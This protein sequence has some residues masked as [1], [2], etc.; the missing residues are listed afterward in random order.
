MP[1]AASTE[2]LE[3]TVATLRAGDDVDAVYACSR[4]DRLVA[5]SGTPYLALELRDRTGAIP[6]RAFRNADVLAGRF[7]RGDLGQGRGT[8]ERF[9]DEVAGAGGG[10]AR[11]G[12]GEGDPPAV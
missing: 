4:K 1:P 6:G 10:V 9:R 8:V 12:E 7:Q 5:R 3:T 2:S 11:A